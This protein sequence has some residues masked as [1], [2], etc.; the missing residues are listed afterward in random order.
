MGLCLMAFAGML[1]WLPGHPAMLLLSVLGYVAFFAFGLG[2]SVWVYMAEIFPNHIRGRAM[3][4]ATVVLWL[5]VSVVTATF[6][7]LIKFF[8]APG[9]FLGYALVCAASFAYIYIRLPGDEV[10]HPRRNRDYLVKR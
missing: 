4:V 5:A 10:P 2:S 3:S 6:L 1:Q 7:S 9:V 8:T